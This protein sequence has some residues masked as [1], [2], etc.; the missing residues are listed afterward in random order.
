M[1]APP[2]SITAQACLSLIQRHQDM[3]KD[4]APGL[5]KACLQPAMLYTGQC[6]S[7]FLS[8]YLG[9][10]WWQNPSCNTAFVSSR[11][12]STSEAGRC[13]C[14]ADQS[15][16]ATCLYPLRL[17]QMSKNSTWSHCTCGL[18]SPDKSAGSL[19]RNNASKTLFWCY[20]W[21]ASAS[22]C[23]YVVRSSLSRSQQDQ[24]VPRWL[25]PQACVY[26][27]QLPLH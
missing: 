13:M 11:E 6:T 3:S 22:P 20:K 7:S 2:G 16:P 5:P 19:S 21:Q 25:H 9:I 18:P 23:L 24:C 1:S 4:Q 14:R 26:I 27:A 12:A 10:S 8:T 15:V 17:P